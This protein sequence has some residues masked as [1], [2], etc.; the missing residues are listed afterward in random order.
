MN[1]DALKNKLDQ[2]IKI[3]LH[4]RMP[5]ENLIVRCSPMNLA[6]TNNVINQIEKHR[7]IVRCPHKNTNNEQCKLGIN[8]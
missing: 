3:K 8:F 1:P 7:L 2:K 4:K 6:T 5:I